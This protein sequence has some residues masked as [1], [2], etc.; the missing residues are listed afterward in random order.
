MIN[1]AISSRVKSLFRT[2]LSL[3]TCQLIDLSTLISSP[4]PPQ[5][6]VLQQ[7]QSLNS[8]VS[9]ASQFRIHT[10]A[11]YLCRTCN[12]LES[13]GSLVGGIIEE[14][15]RT[16]LARIIICPVVALGAFAAEPFAYPAGWRLLLPLSMSVVTMYDMPRDEY[17]YINSPAHSNFYS[18]VCGT[19]P[20]TKW[21][22]N[23]NDRDIRRGAQASSQA[24]RVGAQ[25]SEKPPQ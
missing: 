11:Q 25:L 22:N 17:K 6:Q 4:Q 10:W 2:T 9:F 18:S 20:A 5:Q 12:R 24:L 14:A 1:W 19:Q 8:I 16:V 13:G 3:I 23:N 21:N 7:Q 15:P